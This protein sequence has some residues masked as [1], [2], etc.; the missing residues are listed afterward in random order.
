MKDKNLILWDKVKKL[1]CKNIPHP[2]IEPGSWESESLVSQ[3]Y[4]LLM[5]EALSIKLSSGLW[6]LR[7]ETN[8]VLNIKK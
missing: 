7:H 2:G 4:W 1:E 8:L 5:R 3:P 6:T